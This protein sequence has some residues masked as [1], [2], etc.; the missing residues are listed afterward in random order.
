MQNLL[1]IEEFDPSDEWWDQLLVQGGMLNDKYLYYL[2]GNYHLQAFEGTTCFYFN[3]RMM[4]DLGLEFPYQLVRDGK[5]TLDKLYE[6]AGVAANLN[7]EES[8]DKDSAPMLFT[9]TPAL[10]I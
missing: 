5:W 1:D 10:P 3:K 8:F 9:V 7:G 2:G 6:Y 4:T